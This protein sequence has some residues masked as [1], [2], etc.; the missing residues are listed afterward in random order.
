MKNMK[1]INIDK[2]PN[3]GVE[4][5][6]NYENGGLCIDEMHKNGVSV[7]I[8]YGIYGDIFNAISLSL[9]ELRKHRAD[10]R[11]VIL[12]YAKSS[13]SSIEAKYLVDVLEGTNA[14]LDK[15]I[16]VL[17]SIVYLKDEI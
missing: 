9:R 17:E 6:V 11:K 16:D 3:I 1:D 12:E 2:R 14:E 8:P 13:S 10:N 7:Y 4:D 5:M 15:S